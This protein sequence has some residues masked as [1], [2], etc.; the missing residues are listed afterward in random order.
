MRRTVTILFALILAV[1]AHAQVEQPRSRLEIGVAGGMNLNK[2][3]FQPSIRQK[4]LDGWGGGLNIRYTSE[5]YFSM[6]C[7]TQ[8]EINFSQRGWEEDFD[9]GTP[10]SYCRT[11][12]YVEIPLFAHVSWGKEERGFQFFLNLGPQFGF[13]LNE[14]ESYIGSWQPQERPIALQPIY[15]KKIQNTFDYG[16]AGGAGIEWKTRAGNFFVEGRYYYGLSDI[17]HNSKTDDFGRSA[18]LT[19]YARIGYSIRIF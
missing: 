2:M 15:G 11:I 10:N 18:N 17:F 16:I 6:I 5:K 9:D 19:I 4:Y 13:M 12:D 14:R 1:T 3:E 8:L 7:A